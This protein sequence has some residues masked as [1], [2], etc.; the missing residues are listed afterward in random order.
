MNMISDHP[1]FKHPSNPYIKIWRYMDVSK[2]VSLLLDRSL[3]FSAA[4][5]LGDPFE[6][7][8]TRLQHDL[9]AYILAHRHT[10]PRLASWRGMQDGP[11]KEMFK[12]QSDFRKRWPSF[13][14]VNC[15]HMNEHESDAMWRLYSTANEAICVQST[16]KRLAEGLPSYVFAG[17]VSYIDY[18]IGIIPPNNS[19]N[20]FLYKRMSFAHERELRAIIL[21]APAEVQATLPFNPIDG[22]VVVSIDLE[23]MIETIH[24]SPT[25]PTWFKDTVERLI[26]SQGINI[27]VRQSKLSD[28]PLF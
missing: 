12:V 18:E 9:P 20:A 22:G 11:L 24:V 25:S 8:T 4:D 6:G 13:T 28:K 5:R 2:F 7:S 15:W 10:D 1:S 21:G 26:K 14:Y 19:L 3:Y 16:F 17:E 23:K 27:P